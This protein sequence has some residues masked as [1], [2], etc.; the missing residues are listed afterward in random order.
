MDGFRRGFHE[1]FANYGLK[2]LIKGVVGGK[3]MDFQ[4]GLMPCVFRNVYALE[5]L[6][7]LRLCVYAFDFTAELFIRDILLG[8]R[9]ATNNMLVVLYIK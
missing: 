4:Q 8:L 9:K 2:L 1:R 3:Y 7:G 6:K 5:P